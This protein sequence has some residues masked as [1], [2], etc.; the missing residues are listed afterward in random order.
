[1]VS[2]YYV[3]HHHHHYLVVGGLASITENIGTN[4][5]LL[6]LAQCERGGDYKLGSSIS[7]PVSSVK[8]QPLNIVM[9]RTQPVGQEHG[10]THNILLDVPLHSVGQA[11]SLVPL[12]VLLQGI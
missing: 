2:Q 1:M 10:F 11:V 3:P 7:G 8:L 9:I 12:G 6:E 5:L 4:N